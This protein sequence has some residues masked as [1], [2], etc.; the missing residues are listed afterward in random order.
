MV[1]SEANPWAK[2]GGLA[3]VLEALP[4]ALSELGHP[5]AVVIPRY[6]A[7][8]TAPARRI[9]DSVPIALGPSIYDVAIWQLLPSAMTSNVSMFFID[10]PV[11]FDRPNL[12]GDHTG[13][14]PDNHIRFAILSRAALEIARRVFPTDIFHCHD[15]QSALVPV[16][17]KDDRVTDPTFA[18]ARSVLTVHNLGYQGIFGPQAL[19]AIGLPKTI[20]HPGAIE[21]WGRVNFLK[22]GIVFADALT[23]VSRKY[24]EEIQTPEYGEGLEGVIAS[25]STALTGILNGIDY[26]RWNPSKDHLIAAP[27]S[28]ANLSGKIQCKRALVQAMGLPETALDRPLIGIVSRFAT[29]KGFE[30]LAEAA[31]DIFAQDVYLAALGNGEPRI[32]SIFHDLEARFPGR[33]AVRIGYD[34]ALAHG[35]EAGADIFLMPSR[36]EPCG[37]NQIYSLRYGTVPVV[38]AT[39]GLDDTITSTPPARAT[40]FK[41][42]AYN[43]KALREAVE[44]ACRLWEDRK[45][46]TAMMLRGMDKDFSWAASAAEYSRLYDSLANPG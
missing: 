8:R 44:E 26:D 23:T 2:S 17:L 42:V 28:P 41:F 9:I 46:W 29:Q 5:V 35:I 24:A 12:Y 37:L 7:A 25:R 16:Y 3:D 45:A 18:G 10:E 14:F 32:E 15:W 4:A 27:Y 38:R 43:G 34:E 39:G 22:A 1:S 21:F 19:D 33:V 31:P 20:F 30:L 40:G 6:M 13:D 36:Y 11:L